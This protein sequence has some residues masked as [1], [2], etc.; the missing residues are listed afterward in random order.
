MPHEVAARAGLACVSMI[1]VIALAFGSRLE[2]TAAVMLIV[3]VTLDNALH[4]Y[5]AAAFQP[6]STIMD[7]LVFLA[8]AIGMLASQR[9]WLIWASAYQLLALCCDV[10]RVLDPTVARA[11]FITASISFGYGVSCALAYG[12]LEAQLGS[13]RRKPRP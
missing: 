2:R 7:G 4:D 8:F 5:H 9:R 1:Y 10:L 13:R 6:A 12:V 3:Q 11:P